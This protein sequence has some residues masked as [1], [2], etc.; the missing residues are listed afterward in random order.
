MQHHG[1]LRAGGA[2]PEDPRQRGAARHG[3]EWVRGPEGARSGRR[4]GAAARGAARGGGGGSAWRW[5]VSGPGERVL[6]VAEARAIDRDAHERLGLPTLLLMEN[7]ARS[8]AE[9]AKTLG[10]RFVIL[11]GAGNNGGDGL[12]AARHLG[13]S[14][15]AVHLL[16]EPD[17]ARAPD[18]ALQLRVLRAAGWRV[19]V[20]T[21]PDAAAHRGA[22]WIDGLFGTGLDRELVGAARE[23][24]EAFDR[25]E[26]RKLCIDIPSGLH[27]DTGEVLGAACQ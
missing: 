6:S 8:V 14:V 12:A 23:W 25:A 11:A 13:R 3:A 17:P 5:F 7:A 21:L 16:A 27:G 15:C 9:V 1:R 24:V 4:S 18:A 2:R 20:G 22:L 10:E 26:G 19:V